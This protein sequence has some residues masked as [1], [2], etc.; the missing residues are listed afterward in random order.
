MKRVFTSFTVILSVTAVLG[1]IYT[2]YVYNYIPH[3]KYSNADFDIKAFVSSVDKDNDGID[4]QTDILASVR[5]YVATEPKYKSKYY[6]ETGYPNDEYGVCTDVVGF[7]LMGAGYDL[8]ELVN[9]DVLASPESYDIDEPDKAIDFR[10]VRNLKVYFARHAK[11]L[12]LDVHDIEAWQG[13]DIVIFNDHI[14][15]VSDVRNKN[16]VAFVIHN[17]NPI[18]KDYEEDILEFRSDLVGHYRISE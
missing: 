15:V 9:E 3:G 2:L 14:G 1:C 18:Q 4:D 17:M 16:G 12:T 5:E 6:S 8:M 10:R 13:G 7:G 11:E